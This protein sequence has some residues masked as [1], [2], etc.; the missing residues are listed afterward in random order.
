MTILHIILLA[1]LLIYAGLVL[2]AAFS[3]V[4]GTSFVFDPGQTH[5]TR[6]CIIICARNE[7]QAIGP[8]LQSI[9]E[10]QFDRSLLEIIF[11][12]DASSDRTLAVATPLLE[13]SGIRFQTISSL[14]PQGKKKSITR[15]ID[16]CNSEL[17]VTRDADTYTNSLNWLG[18]IVGFHEQSR[19]EFIIAPLQVKEDPSFIT[20]LQVFENNALSILTG[21]FALAGH[22]FLCSGA[23]LAFTRALFH[24]MNGYSNHSHIASGDDVLFLAEVKQKEPATI[25]YLKHS[26]ATVVTYPIKAFRPLLDQKIR[27]SAKFSVNPNAL[28]T[29]MAVLVLIVHLIP[30]FFIAEAL[31]GGHLRLIGLFFVFSGFLIDFLLLFLASRYFKKAVSWP[32]LLPAW[33]AYGFFA[34]LV[35]VG[36]WFY[37]PQW[38]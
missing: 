28:N 36:G 33:I 25:G 37:K 11:V 27:W 18:C 38:K 17:I 35:G 19:R 14:K 5:H 13:Q 3:F 8:C 10:Q 29:L 34:I 6:T 4:A 12:N 24:R 20:Q 16:L 2:Y 7:E 15:A 32:W 1:A 31:F 9:F 21:G 30:C 23:N 26:D 22:P